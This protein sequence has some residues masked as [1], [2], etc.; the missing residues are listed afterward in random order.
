[1]TRSALGIRWSITFVGCVMFLCD[2]VVAIR[3]WLSGWPQVITMTPG[4]G[5]VED[6]EVSPMPFTVAD[7]LILF[8]IILVHVLVVYGVWKVWGGSHNRGVP[9]HR[10]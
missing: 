10:S 5:G 6:I 9:L 1:M 7:W 8:A 4:D 2:L 3:L